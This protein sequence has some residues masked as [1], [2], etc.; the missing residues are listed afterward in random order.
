LKKIGYGYSFVVSFLCYALRLG[1]ISLAWTPRWIVAI[2]LLMQG[3]TYALFYTTSAAY[4]NSIAPPGA[5]AT[6]QGIV[7]GMDDGIGLCFL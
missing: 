1:L 5:S 6:V 2:E 4:A 7:T 3:P